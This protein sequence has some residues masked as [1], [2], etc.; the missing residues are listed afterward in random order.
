MGFSYEA[1]RTGCELEMVHKGVCFRIRDDERG[2]L[3]RIV[4]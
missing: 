2:C 1:M 3:T 4:Q